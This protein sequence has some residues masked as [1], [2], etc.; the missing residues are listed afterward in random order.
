MDY[1]SIGKR[2]RVTRTRSCNSESH[3]GHVVSRRATAVTRRVGSG[4]GC[5]GPVRRVLQ[6]S[7][8]VSG[9]NRILPI[10]RNIALLTPHPTLPLQH[11]WRASAPRAAESPAL[12]WKLYIW[13]LATPI[14]G[15][16]DPISVRETRYRVPDIGPP[17]ISN[18]HIRYRVVISGVDI[19]AY[20]S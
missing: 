2:S 7:S 4:S 1:K 10:T 17:S 11:T 15:V 14:S 9:S 20:R 18:V 3:G 13:I 12:R 16:G 5:A 6:D 8:T 19:E